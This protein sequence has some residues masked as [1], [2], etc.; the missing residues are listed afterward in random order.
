MNSHPQH[1]LRKGKK[2]WEVIGTLPLKMKGGRQNN[3]RSF[4]S[5]MKKVL[6]NIPDHEFSNLPLIQ[7]QKIPQIK[8][9]YD[10]YFKHNPELIN[11]RTLTDIVS[12]FDIGV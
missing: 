11:E 3:Y 1:I 8:R 2:S 7:L 9:I 10:R 5:G 6:S 12:I 4:L